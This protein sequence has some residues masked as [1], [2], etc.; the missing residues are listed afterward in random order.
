MDANDV[1]AIISRRRARFQAQL[2]SGP[3]E[4]MDEAARLIAE[5][6]D[7]LLAEIEVAIA[8]RPEAQRLNNK[9]EAEILGDQ[10]QLGG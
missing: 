3:Q 1:I 2:R 9:A 4:G 6:Y 8:D 10:G 7:A 5:E